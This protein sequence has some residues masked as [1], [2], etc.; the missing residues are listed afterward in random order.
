V[1]V[2]TGAMAQ[3]TMSGEAG[4]AYVSD[5]NITAAS[6]ATNGV[7]KAQATTKGLAQTDGS[8]TISASE[9]LGVGMT[10]SAS[11]TVDLKGRSA[12]TAENS[13]MSVGGAFGTV[14]IGSI[15]AGNGIVG[16]GSAGGVGR[17]FDDGV[18]LDG[19]TNV[20]LVQY[21]TPELMTGLKAFINTAEIIPGA[22]DGLFQ[23]TGVGVNYSAG[24]LTV[25]FDTTSYSG[26]AVAAA[27]SAKS[28]ACLT[29][30]VL[31]AVAYKT[32]C[33][34]TIAQTGNAALTADEVLAA[35]IDSRQRL[36]FSYD[37]GMARIGY[38]TQ[39]KSYAGTGV[40]NKQSVMGVTVPFGAFTVSLAKSS[41]KN[42]GATTKTTGTDLGVNYAMSKRTA[43]NLSS[44][45]VKTTGSDSNTFTRLR[46]K[47]TF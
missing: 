24:P 40:D 37:L 5:K 29:S 18:A 19:D 6:A 42:Q 1:A 31:T 16:L 2:T 20:D 45:S 43:L 32:A 47:H 3:V 28:A 36:S 21:T 23:G 4:F 46:L 25:V 11:H 9:D 34:G 13:T 30:G 12:V 17:G 14:L 33:A 7:A 10:L 39:T 22:G 15:A 35:Q 41:N 26:H 8:I 38:G 27:V 44:K